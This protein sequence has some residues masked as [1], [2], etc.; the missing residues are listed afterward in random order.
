MMA[1]TEENKVYC[2]DCGVGPFIGGKLLSEHRDSVHAKVSV[3][4]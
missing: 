4:Y 2:H 1:E 3:A